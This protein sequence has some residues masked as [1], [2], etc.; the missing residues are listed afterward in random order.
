[1]KNVRPL[2]PVP[3]LP[4]PV[5]DYI[6]GNVQAIVEL[7]YCRDNSPPPDFLLT[8]LELL[9]GGTA[10]HAYKEGY[11]R[12]WQTYAELA[13]PTSV[14]VGESVRALEWGRLDGR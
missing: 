7:A 14:S 5:Q 11:T 13:P 3:H 6:D 2:F 12:S 10:T 9:F 4:D 8:R 1:M